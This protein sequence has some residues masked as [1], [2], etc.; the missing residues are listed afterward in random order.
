M[1][2][3]SLRV[4]P[5]GKTSGKAQRKSGHPALTTDVNDIPLA[6]RAAECRKRAKDAL[7]AAGAATFAADKE[8]RRLEAEGWL[9]LAA[10]IDVMTGL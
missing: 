6:Q 7:F 5:S 3:A 4:W 2:G 10:K 9:L 8:S 1:A